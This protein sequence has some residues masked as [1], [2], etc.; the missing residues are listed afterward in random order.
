[1]C[2]HV[3]ACVVCVRVCAYV[4]ANV[5]ASDCIIRLRHAIAVDRKPLFTSP[6]K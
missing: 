3:C 2:V 6:Y 5:R 1:M 4:R